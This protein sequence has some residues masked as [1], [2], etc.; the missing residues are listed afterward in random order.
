MPCSHND[1]CVAFYASPKPKK[2]VELAEN[3]AI[4]KGRTF[5][6]GVGAQKAGTTWLSFYLR[7]HPEVY[8][9]PIKEMH[10]W[11]NRNRDD[12]WPQSMFRKKLAKRESEM[13][14]N[15]DLPQKGAVAL[16]DRIRM[17]TSIGGYRRFF[18][19]RVTHEQVFGEI[20][21]AYCALERE[22]LALIRREYPG[23]K[24]IFLL[25]NPVDR[26]W[27]QL[28]FS[29]KFETL[30]ELEPKVDGAFGKKLYRERY[31]YVSAMRN[32]RAEF[33]AQ[34]LHFQFYEHLFTPEAINGI[35]RFLEIEPLPAKFERSRNVSV[36]M[37]L[38]PALRSRMIHQLADQYTYCRDLFAGQLPESWLKDLTQLD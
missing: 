22:E 28:R 19:R 31:D 34:N 23:A 11:G 10:F 9:S 16:R 21:P 20:T 32:L 14:E 26:M 12:N 37:P 4:L 38:S 1:D 7:D 25:R 6:L 33:P 35:C 8:F 3:L 18:R 13:L 24:V 17:G 29:E 15:P 30:E 2:S 5:F 27:S 36:K